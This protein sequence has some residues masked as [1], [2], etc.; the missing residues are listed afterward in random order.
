MNQEIGRLASSEGM[1]VLLLATTTGYQTRMFGEAAARLG[2]ELV[3]ATDRCDQLE[4]PWGDAALAV[5]YHEESRSVDAVLEAGGGPGVVSPQ[6]PAA[7]TDREV[8]VLRR[9]ECP[10]LFRDGD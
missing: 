2:I 7:L 9:D 4:D 6:W 1:R 10:A 8:E 5:R 3:Y